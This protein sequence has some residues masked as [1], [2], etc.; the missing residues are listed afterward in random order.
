MFINVQDFICLHLSTI[1]ETEKCIGFPNKDKT[2]LIFFLFRCTSF[3]C[4]CRLGPRW[5]FYIHIIIYSEDYRSVSI[6]SQRHYS[7]VLVYGKPRS[8]SRIPILTGYI[9]LSYV[10]FFYFSFYTRSISFSSN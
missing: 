8:S 1:I 6:K 7:L 2:K 4:V 5:V 3:A 10:T 9:S